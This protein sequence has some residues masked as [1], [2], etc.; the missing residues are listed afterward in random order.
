MSRREKIDKLTDGDV[1]P[2]ALGLLRALIEA[3]QTQ[4]EA[5]EVLKQRMEAEAQLSSAR[6]AEQAALLDEVRCELA[7][8][9]A[10]LET[11]I[12]KRQAAERATAELEAVVA[13]VWE[14]LPSQPPAEMRS[15][16]DGA[17][18]R[19]AVDTSTDVAPGAGP[20]ADTVPTLGDAA[21]LGEAEDANGASGIPPGAGGATDAP[22]RWLSLRIDLSED[23]VEALVRLAR[24]RGRGAEEYVIDLVRRE[25]RAASA[26]QDAGPVSRAKVPR[27]TADA[28]G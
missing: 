7:E 10:A 6:E 5:L 23:E 27:N 21:E 28:G 19:A 17:P 24:S 20:V 9:G 8:T 18:A 1:P 22:E 25:L 2:T 16:C 15:P 13:R 3:S 26:R 4:M 14:V 11:E 12:G